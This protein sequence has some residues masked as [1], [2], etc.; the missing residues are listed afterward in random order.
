EHIVQVAAA[1]GLI[2]FDSRSAAAV[3]RTRAADGLE[4]A[5]LIEPALAAWNDSAMQPVWLQR[6]ESDSSRPELVALAIRGASQTGF[7]A[8]APHLGRLVL[9]PR[10]PPQ[11]RLQAARALSQL[12][13]EDVITF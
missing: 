7:T 3:L 9:N 11:L 13:G 6:L 5:Q 2:A 1:R 10:A 4:L 8:A 12:A